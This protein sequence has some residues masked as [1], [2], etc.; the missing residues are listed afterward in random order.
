MII[1]WKVAKKGLKSHFLIDVIHEL[2]PIQ[3]CRETAT[4]IAISNNMS[5]CLHLTSLVMWRIFFFIFHKHM[6][7]LP[8]TFSHRTQLNLNWVKFLFLVN[9]FLC[10]SCKNKT[11]Y[12]AVQTKIKIFFYGLR[13]CIV[14]DWCWWW[15]IY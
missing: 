2:T 12:A 9:F 8:Q 5:T 1:L 3:L 6:S 13:S 10:W 4:I 14:G 15:Y 7:R 11:F